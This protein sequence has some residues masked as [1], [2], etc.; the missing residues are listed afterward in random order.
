MSVEDAVMAELQ[1]L[2]DA[3]PD[4][5]LGASAL[6]LARQMD[7]RVSWAVAKEL[8]ETLGAIRALAPPKKGA[9][10][11]DELAERRRRARAARRAAT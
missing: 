10:K 3:V 8:R 4:S 6:A 7:R 9:N 5:A 11:S 2:G 1:A